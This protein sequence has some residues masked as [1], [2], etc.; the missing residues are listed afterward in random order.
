MAEITKDQRALL[1]V[2]NLVLGPGDGGGDYD[3]LYEWLDK[4]AVLVANLL[5]RPVY[6][7]VD[8]LTKDEVTLDAFLDRVVRLTSDPATEALDVFLIMHGSPG[9]L[10]FDDRSISTQEISERLKAANPFDR[11]R[12]LYS[13]A[14]YGASHAE[15]FVKAGFRTASGAIAVCAN[16]PYE[17]PAQLLRWGSRQ[18]YKSAVTAGNNP[19][20]RLIHDNAAKVMG[21]SDVNSEKIIVGKKYTRITSSVT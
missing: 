5:M 1:V 17:F 18:T 20:F 9:R 10:Y 16:G 15:D 21:F 12:L 2:A 3:K 14:C 4:Y 6:R 19:V 8:S 13:T 7:V 11:L